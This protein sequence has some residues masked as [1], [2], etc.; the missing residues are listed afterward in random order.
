M[1][2][3]VWWRPR[4][5]WFCNDTADWAA[6]MSCSALNPL[7]VSLYKYYGDAVSGLARRSLGTGLHR[8]FR[9]GTKRSN[10]AKSPEKKRRK[11]DS[12]IKKPFITRSTCP[13][14]I[15]FY[16]EAFMFV[17]MGSLMGG[18]GGGGVKATVRIPLSPDIKS[19]GS[20]ISLCSSKWN[21][22]Q[23]SA[24]AFNVFVFMDMKDNHSLPFFLF[25]PQLTAMMAPVPGESGV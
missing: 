7:K 21:I 5:V 6:V 24:T 8:L 13:V 25:H 17:A 14:R 12:M 2:C 11:N 20:L 4:L 9:F 3:V 23:T 22:R 15:F 18:G 10:A 19:Q 16:R 1:L